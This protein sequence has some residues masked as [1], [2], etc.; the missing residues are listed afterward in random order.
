MELCFVSSQASGRAGIARSKHLV[1]F[2]VVGNTRDMYVV[3]I[4]YFSVPPLT[5]LLNDC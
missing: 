4:M 2:V 3:G 5:F 1:Y